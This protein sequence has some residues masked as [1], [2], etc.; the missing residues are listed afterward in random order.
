MIPRRP[1]RRLPPRPAP[2]PLPPPA[3]V[4]K[5]PLVYDADLDALVPKYGRNHFDWNELRADL[6]CPAI[7]PG[8]M[9]EIKSMVDGKRY[10]TKRN[11][12]KSVERAGCAIVGFDRDWERHV[13]KPGVPDR[14]L[15][16]DIVR[17]VKAAVEI[18]A[19]KVP[20]YGPEAR[21]LMRKQR[22]KERESVV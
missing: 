18:E 8:S 6:P 16:A 13:S 12:Y 21:R 19:G 4:Y 7:Q 3:P 2:A 11:Y 9:P 15:E 22:R 17:D 10:D 14:E 1:L 20:S 5:G